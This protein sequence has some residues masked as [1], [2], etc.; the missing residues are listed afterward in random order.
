MQ[1]LWFKRD[2]RIHDHAALS[3]ATKAAPVL[4]LYILEPALWKEPDMSYR[5]YEFL[6]E[7]LLD[8]DAELS[9]L[10]QS[11]VIKVGDAV[12][13]LD[14]LYERY[15]VTALYSHQE[16]W[17]AWT[18][19][20]DKRVKAW[21]KAR[22]LI[23]HEPVQNG[24]IRCLKTRDNWAVRWHALM[25]KPLI[26]APFAL[27][28]ILELQ[29]NE[30]LPQG[31]AAKKATELLSLTADLGLEN[32]GCI[33]RQKASRS[34]ALKLLD[35][36]LHE[37]GLNYTKA[38]SS[39]LTAYEACSRL[40][41][42]LAFGL[43][44]MREIFHR[45]AAEEKRSKSTSTIRSFS[46]RLRWHCHF[47]QKLEDEPNIEFKNLHSAYDG[48]REPEF[49]YDYFNAWKEA[50]TGYP[51]IDACMRALKATGWINFRMR[52]MLMSFAANHLW[53]HWREPALHLARLFTDYEP[54]IHYPQAQMQSG[55]TGI[56]TIRIYNPIK[57]SL[58]Q[59]P[60]G[61]FI[62]K[63][64]PELANMPAKY[65]HTP[66]ELPLM[67]NNYP[68]PIV[69]EKI[70]RKAAA[71]K[72]Y[73]LRKNLDYKLEAKEIVIKHASRK[74]RVSAVRSKISYSK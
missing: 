27:E 13:V 6:C 14:K 68:Q 8:L 26:K 56:N 32:D 37:R 65:I 64:I 10:G 45:I 60:E 53:L 41:P 24:V 46:A 36:F 7:A 67:M 31:L 42:Y 22:N 48:L 54:G 33:L 21:A 61:I 38:M 5:H 47:I 73:G 51:M 12:S 63:W 66:W 50:R 35:T 39:P 3:M 52:A 19:S 20:R 69:D 59:D 34:E 17:N 4:P 1:I 70:A 49:N 74:N 25:R 23:W 40:S 29:K 57:Q 58:D 72:L 28:P 43:I 11:L 71:D 2:L 16:T 18:Y 55:T 44:S 62:R 15:P 30:T 9:S